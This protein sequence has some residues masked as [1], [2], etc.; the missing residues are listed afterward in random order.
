MLRVRCVASLLVGGLLDAGLHDGAPE[1]L[2]PPQG[3]ISVSRP[4]KRVAL[5]ESNPLAPAV[6]LCLQG[7]RPGA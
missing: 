6:G 4:S 1:D 3:D 5:A 7:A 2:L